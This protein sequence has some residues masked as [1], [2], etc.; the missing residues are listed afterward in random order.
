MNDCDIRAMLNDAKS[1]VSLSDHAD[2]SERDVSSIVENDLRVL[3][4]TK[5]IDILRTLFKDVDMD[6]CVDWVEA[7]V[8]RS[9]A[10]A[11]YR[12]LQPLICTVNGSGKNSIGVT[13][14]TCTISCVWAWG[15]TRT[16]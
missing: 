1:L 12:G 6:T 9:G 4:K 15:C 2:L 14:P 13:W 16:C 7:N 8:V 11:R 5:D 3:F 10:R